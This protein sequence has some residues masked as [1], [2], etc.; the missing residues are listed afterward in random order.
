MA[1]HRVGLPRLL[2]IRDNPTL[3]DLPPGGR[4]TVD[5]Q[6]VAGLG[7]SDGAVQ[8]GGLATVRSVPRVHPRL[9]TLRA[10]RRGPSSPGSRDPQGPD[11]GAGRAGTGGLR[12]LQFA[13]R[14][15]A[16]G[17]SGAF[18]VCYAVFPE[19]GTVALVMVFGKN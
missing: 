12:K 6:W 18:R 1:D 17:K 2:I 4:V 15:A 13:E 8:A 19:F 3:L 14:G 5:F 9:G 16:R 7:E 10:G 11:P